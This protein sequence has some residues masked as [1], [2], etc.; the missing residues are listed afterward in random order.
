MYCALQLCIFMFINSLIYYGR[1]KSK[2]RHSDTHAVCWRTEILTS[3]W[4]AYGTIV[5]TPWFR[6]ATVSQLNVRNAS[7]E[8][9]GCRFTENKKKFLFWGYSMWT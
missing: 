8:S 7:S 2:N 4:S 9:A 1:D 6:H 5:L 3:H